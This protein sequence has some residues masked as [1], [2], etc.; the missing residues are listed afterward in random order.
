MNVN[1][2]YPE[3]ST[4]KDPELQSAQL[5]ARARFLPDYTVRAA[6]N[7]EYLRITAEHYL[8]ARRLTV[9]VTKLHPQDPEAVSTDQQNIIDD[10]FDSQ[11][12]NE[13]MV[14]PPPQPASSPS[15]EYVVDKMT[16][17]TQQMIALV[18]VTLPGKGLRER[19]GRLLI[20]DAVTLDQKCSNLESSVY[21]LQIS[22]TSRAHPEVFI[23]KIPSSL[24][25][26]RLAAL[27]PRETDSTQTEGD[28]NSLKRSALQAYRGNHKDSCCVSALQSESQDFFQ[29]AWDR[30]ISHLREATRATVLAS[31][32]D[33][34]GNGMTSVARPNSR[35][36]TSPAM[37]RHS[38]VVADGSGIMDSIEER[39]SG[40]PP[41][42]SPRKNNEGFAKAELTSPWR[43]L[44]FSMPVTKHGQ[45]PP[46]TRLEAPKESHSNEEEEESLTNRSSSPT[47][48]E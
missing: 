32:V 37:R 33:I 39:Y 18:L 31:I 2:I 26:R 34:G 29:S 42:D 8:L 41:F 17:V 16:L 38:V 45:P 36:T 1:D 27:E 7:I 44:R 30:H 35:S 47:F 23:R 6:T 13:K 19:W 24:S 5:A 9:W 14:L 43:P 28:T 4:L 12:N 21:Q 3:V 46:V 22:I 25:D 40:S 20:T 48:K 11:P 15:S 10:V